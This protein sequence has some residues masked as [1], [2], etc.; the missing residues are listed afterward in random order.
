MQKWLLLALLTVASAASATNVAIS[1]ASPSLAAASESNTDSS[2]DQEGDFSF[3]IGAGMKAFKANFKGSSVFSSE[4]S[5]FDPENFFSNGRYTNPNFHYPLDTLSLGLKFKNEQE[6]KLTQFVKDFTKNTDKS[7]KSLHLNL[8]ASYKLN[9]GNGIVYQPE[10]KVGYNFF[11]K[12]QSSSIDTDGINRSQLNNPYVT[13]CVLGLADLKTKLIELIT[14]KIP[15]LTT[16]QQ[17]LD[18]FNQAVN[19]EYKSQKFLRV[20]PNQR[21]SGETQIQ[22]YLDQDRDLVYFAKTWLQHSYNIDLNFLKF[23]FNY[24]GFTFSPYAGLS[25]GRFKATVTDNALEKLE[26]SKEEKEKNSDLKHEISGSFFLPG[27]TVGFDV[28]APLMK[29]DMFNLKLGLSAAYTWYKT[30]DIFSDNFFSPKLTKKFNEKV[31]ELSGMSS[32]N[33]IERDSFKNRKLK[34]LVSG[35]EMAPRT[36]YVGGSLSFEF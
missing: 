32:L 10:I 1:P 34:V 24:N 33:P 2:A 20:L 23:G 27:I 30:V 11:N 18:F 31:S 21:K 29:N 16:D 26:F 7:D 17:R 8:S 9:L 4:I 35:S 28:A 36:W 14:T 15:A 12:A 22:A 3:S 5:K 6:P 25:F 19:Q 13:P